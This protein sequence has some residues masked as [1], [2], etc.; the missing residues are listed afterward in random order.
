MKKSVYLCGQFGIRSL[1]CILLKTTKR[2]ARLLMRTQEIFA[3]MYNVGVAVRAC[4]V[5][6][7]SFLYIGIS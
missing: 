3:A 4:S 7:L 1:S 5:D 2:Y 6:C